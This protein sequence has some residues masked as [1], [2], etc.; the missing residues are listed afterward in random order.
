MYGYLGNYVCHCNT[1]TLFVFIILQFW[2]RKCQELN[3]LWDNYVV[4]SAEEDIRKE[5]KGI[6]MIN[7]VTG[8]IEPMFTKS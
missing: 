8:R 7:P 1:K 4:T 5:F 6:D 3:I 2:K